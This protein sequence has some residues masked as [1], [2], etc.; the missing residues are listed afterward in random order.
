MVIMAKSRTNRSQSGAAAQG[1]FVEPVNFGGDGFRLTGRRLHRDRC[2]Y[3]HQHQPSVPHG[4]LLHPS[5]CKC[6]L[7]CDL[8]W[9]IGR[10]RSAA[11]VAHGHKKTI[12][13]R[14]LR[15]AEAGGG[16]GAAGDQVGKS[17]GGV[18][19]LAA[20][21]F[22]LCSQILR[23]IRRSGCRHSGSST[24]TVAGE[25]LAGRNPFRRGRA[26]QGVQY[27]APVGRPMA[28]PHLGHGI[29]RGQF[30][31]GGQEHAEP[32]RPSFP[33]SSPTGRRRCPRRVPCR[34]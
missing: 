19:L 8:E 28:G 17:R 2:V 16:V 33:V 20:N 30:F 13:T 32:G 4:N 12:V 34:R 9:K 11:L 10:G 23:A 26:V 29:H 18:F 31:Q 24:S 25:L 27:G 14:L 15:A 21:A 7:G 3:E 6:G 1:Q 22:G 5:R